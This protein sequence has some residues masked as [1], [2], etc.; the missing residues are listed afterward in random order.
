MAFPA[1]QPCMFAFQRV[2]RSVM[3][4]SIHRCVPVNELKSPAIVIRVAFHTPT[5]RSVRP[6]K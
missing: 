5:T 2:T 1:G 6:H 4:E 3:I